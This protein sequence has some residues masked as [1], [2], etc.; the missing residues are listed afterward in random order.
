[1]AINP[2]NYTSTQI[3]QFG[4]DPNNTTEAQNGYRLENDGRGGRNLSYVGGGGSSGGSSNG[5]GAFNY[6]D[7]LNRAL[8]ITKQNNAPVV[9]S[10][11]ASKQPLQDRYKS[12][13]DS[14]KGNQVTAE[15]RQTKVTASELAKRG[16]TNDSTMFNQEVTDA[17]NPITQQ[18]SGNIKDAGYAQ[19]ADLQALATQIAKLK[20][21][22]LS[23]ASGIAGGMQSGYQFD[24]NYNLQQ[25]QLAEQAAQRAADQAYK[26][27]QYNTIDLPQSQYAVGKPYYQ[28][29]S[30]GGSNV[31]SYYNN[32]GGS[33]YS[34]V[35]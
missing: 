2:G 29:T 10:L 22:D 4:L 34:I 16:I 28:P 15:N 9:Q 27:R 20:A 1:M 7:A 5:G 24:Q 6:Q 33:R 32:S 11:E 14:L 35:G 8:E 23:A 21:G 13:I 12:L 19:E 30:T 17:V 25:K 31:S 18:F 26:E 3:Q